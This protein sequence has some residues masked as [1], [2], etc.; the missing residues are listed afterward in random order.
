MRGRDDYKFL[1]IRDAIASINQKVSL[2]GVIAEFDFPKKTKGT[3][4]LSLFL[5]SFPNLRFYVTALNAFDFLFFY[6]KKKKFKI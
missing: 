3:G 5:L 2:I 6:K 1:E 4:T